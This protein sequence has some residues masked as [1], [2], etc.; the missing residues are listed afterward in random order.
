MFQCLAPSDPFRAIEVNAC[1]TYLLLWKF[2]ACRI[3]RRRR[4][5]CNL[6]SVCTSATQ[7]FGRSEVVKPRSEKL[8]LSCLENFLR[9]I[10]RR[11]PMGFRLAPF[12]LVRVRVSFQRFCRLDGSPESDSAGWLTIWHPKRLC[13]KPWLAACNCCLRPLEW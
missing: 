6:V 8:D 12:L 11:P 9:V 4:N 7:S 2:C 13:L 5:S 1:F 10:L 3:P